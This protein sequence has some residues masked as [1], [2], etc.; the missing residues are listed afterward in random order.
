M[1]TVNVVQKQP[2]WTLEAAGYEWCHAQCGWSRQSLSKKLQSVQNMAACMV[3]GVCRSE[4]IMPVLEDL[5]WLPV[6]QRVVYKTALMVWKC[7]H[8][9]TPAYLSDLCIPLLPSQVVSIC[10]LQ[11]LA[12]YWFHVPRLQLDNKVSQSMD[13]PHGTVC[14]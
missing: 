1:K 5:H 14:P 4:H 11:R 8:G 10:D 2:P 12:L 13:Q 9:V 6:S 7:V 3:S